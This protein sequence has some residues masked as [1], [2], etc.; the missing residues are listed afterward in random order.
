[1]LK[2]KE[3]TFKHY[4]KG[5]DK[6]F[7]EELAKINSELISNDLKLCSLLM[8]NIEEIVSVMNMEPASVKIVGYKLRKKNGFNTKG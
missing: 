4:S 5:V 2:S 1:M 7:Y 6:E 8:V 3:I